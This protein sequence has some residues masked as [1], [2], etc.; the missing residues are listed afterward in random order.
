MS[1][2]QDQ[3]YNGETVV[4]DGM[5]FVQCEFVNCRLIYRGGEVPKLQSCHF[6]QCQWQL[7]EAAR[8]TIMF[9]RGIYHSGPGGRELVEETLKNIRVRPGPGN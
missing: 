6:A 2:F 8:N 1:R 3:K 4:I 7:E 5:E 9:L